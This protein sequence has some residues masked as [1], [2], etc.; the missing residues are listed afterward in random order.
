MCGSDGITGQ[1]ERRRHLSQEKERMKSAHRKRGREEARA[2]SG[3]EAKAR[4]SQ[5]G[6]EVVVA[7]S[8][9]EA[10]KATNVVTIVSV[11]IVCH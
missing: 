7:P 2:G 3:G 4:G 5:C 10:S 9:R 1:A 8:W 6:G 11:S